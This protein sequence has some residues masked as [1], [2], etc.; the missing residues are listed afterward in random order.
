MERPIW[1]KEKGYLHLSPSLKIGKDWEKLASI[2][3]NK[4]FIE[5]YAFYPLI[6]TNIKD[7]KYKKGNSENHTFTK[8]SHTHYD[9][10]THKPIRNAK[11]RPLH[12]ASHF[13]SL[14]YGYY[15][16][17]L[18]EKYSTKLMEIPELNNAITAYRKIP[19]QKDN[20][21][22]KSNIH[23]AK[24][25]FDEIKER[26]KHGNEV[27]V[28]AFDLKS[29]FSSLDHLYLK[30]QWAWLLGKEQLPKDHYNVFKS[31]TK[32]SYVLLDDLRTKRNK[33]GKKAGFDE[34]KLAYIRKNKGHRSFFLDN[35][36]FRN[37]IKDGKLPIYKNPF[38][39][40]LDN[41]KKVNIGIP[42]GLPIS[43]LL[44]NLYLYE[45]DLQI[46]KKVTGEIGG[47]YRRYSD[48]ILIVC[49][50]HNEIEIELFVMSLIENFKIKISPE[51]TEKFIF[52]H[53]TN[54]NSNSGQRLESYKISR[55]KEGQ[56]AYTHSPLIYLG[57]EFRGYNVCIK[58]TNLSKYYRKI[59]S[60]I[61]RR[62][63]RTIK[64]IN[65]NPNT[66]KALYIN[67]LKKVYNL[68]LKKKEN[69]I[70][71]LRTIKRK[72]YRLVK[73]V[74]GYFNFE[75]FTPKNKKESNYY[76]YVLRCCEVFQEDSFK[77]Q[78]RKRKHIAYCAINKH[79]T[80]KIN[81]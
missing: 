15:A 21:K 55:N 59:I 20:T 1:L 68:P 12:Y 56:I 69:I 14:V 31:C 13:D 23:F 77:H 5:Q 32:F 66:N 80:K 47:Y 48:D 19:T 38:W 28:L 39:R 44:A 49:N 3:Q 10:D 7:R 50:P 61:K 11:L 18:N 33:K 6:H 51:K 4:K 45:F 81:K 57:F 29:F 76:S 71:E 17:I 2:L 27:L 65:E 42:Q 53:V 64:L 79:F 67:Q 60:V 40:K 63:N 73:H 54:K 74:N 52:K 16:H 36:D 58:S 24:E 46:I 78:V 75:H 62:S 25:C 41:N 30:K 70:E 9:I 37:H 35:E 22:G 8:R 43:A 34:S 26:A 72:R